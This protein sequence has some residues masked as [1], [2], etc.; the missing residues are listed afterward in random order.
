MYANFIGCLLPKVQAIAFGAKMYF[1]GKP[2]KHG[3]FSP[4]RVSDGHCKQCK[5]IYHEEN[6]EAIFKR[7]AEWRKTNPV[8]RA[9]HLKYLKDYAKENKEVLTQ[10]RKEYVEKNRQAIRDRNNARN[11]KKRGNG[12]SFKIHH[13]RKMRIEQK[14]K[15]V[16]CEN[17][18]TGKGNCHIDH[19]LPVSLGGSS[20][21]SNIQLLC[22]TCNM[23]KSSKHPDDW[24]EEI[25][26]VAP[27]ER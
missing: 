1:T 19:I 24:H 20:E 8:A 3:H 22:P 6:K 14:G 26:W 18:I 25:G 7:I 5:F 11:A 23:R 16:Y 15:C 4:R 9:A 21:I 12:G 2:C 13:I 10:K 27:Q 17:A